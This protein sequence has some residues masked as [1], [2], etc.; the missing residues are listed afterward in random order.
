MTMAA[1]NLTDTP[2]VVSVNSPTTS[3]VP[4][5][6]LSVVSTIEAIVTEK[7]ELGRF[8]ERSC[9]ISG[10][11]CC[12][13]NL[14]LSPNGKWAVFFN[15]IDGSAGLSIVNVDTNKQW[16]ISYYEI[17]G[18]Y[19]GDVTVAIEHWSHDGQYLYVSPQMAGSGGLFWFWRDYIQLFRI[20]LEGGTWVDTNMGSAFSFSPDD[21]FIVY[22]REQN[23]VIHDLQTGQEQTFAV[24][25]E[26]RAFG[27]FV[28]SQ[29]SKQLIFI[30]SSV[31]ELQS[32]EL[33]DQANGFT[34][35]LL[36]TANRETQVKIEKDDR[37]LYPI[38]WQAPSVVLLESLYQVGSDGTLHPNSE[39]YQIDLETNE[40][41]KSESP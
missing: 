17:T 35:F 36:Q 6:T 37:Y 11:C 24:P 15:T 20:T 9:V 28:W 12:V 22:R 31:E 1:P 8:Y 3:T 40:I 27:R 29:D 5:A 32:D 39:K 21:R 2:K 4:P 14:G 41:S 7:P 19:G 23:V 26:Y 33:S 25:S 38:E 30:G 18:T 16:D 34:L 10:L 13:S